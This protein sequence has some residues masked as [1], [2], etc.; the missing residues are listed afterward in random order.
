MCQTVGLKTKAT[1]KQLTSRAKGPEERPKRAHAGGALLMAE[2]ATTHS[3]VDHESLV[4]ARWAR[5]LGKT[6]P[7]HTSPNPDLLP[8]V[9]AASGCESDVSALLP[10]C[11]AQLAR[12]RPWL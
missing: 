7:P 10:Q 2:L 4:G 11:L 8:L 6:H 12:L 3:G 1:E 5:W 9:N